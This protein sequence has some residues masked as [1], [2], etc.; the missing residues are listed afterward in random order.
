MALDRLVGSGPALG[1]LPIP[2]AAPQRADTPLDPPPPPPRT[3]SDSRECTTF[4]LLSPVPSNRPIRSRPRPPPQVARAALH[5]GSSTLRPC[6]A[7]L[8]AA[9]FPPPQESS[10]RGV[11]PEAGTGAGHTPSGKDTRRLPPGHTPPRVCR[12]H[13]AHCGVGPTHPVQG[14][15][16]VR[17]PPYGSN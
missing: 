15:P 8:L 12:C 9:A 16:G 2:R 7:R 1:A 10:A 13:D 11:L 5:V 14:S 3:G 17:A 6:A 4:P